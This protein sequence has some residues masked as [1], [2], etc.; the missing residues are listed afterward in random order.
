[1]TGVIGSIFLIAIDKSGAG[2]TMFITCIAG[3]A[4]IF[5]Y[6]KKQQNIELANKDEELV[7][8]KPNE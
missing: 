8:N 4:G 3:I 2:L 1:M 7:E 6:G 5:L